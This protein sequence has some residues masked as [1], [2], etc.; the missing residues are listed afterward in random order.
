M[1]IEFDDTILIDAIVEKVV[2]RLKPLFDNARTSKGDELMNVGEV[3]KYLKV[4]KSWVYEKIH[5]NKIPF[6]KAGRFPRFRKKH[7]D[8]WLEN[9]YSVT[10]SAYKPLKKKG[11]NIK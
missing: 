1:K 3:A 11:G 5:T 4:K 2:E 7:I 8:L 6:Q 9:P 10:S